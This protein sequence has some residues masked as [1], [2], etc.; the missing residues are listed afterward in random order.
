M[1]CFS[2]TLNPA[3]GSA[4]LG[5]LLLFEGEGEFFPL[6]EECGPFSAEGFQFGGVLLGLIGGGEVAE[7]G[8]D[9]GYG[10]FEA[11]DLL[12]GVLEAVFELF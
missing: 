6:G 9:G 11:G 3:S 4:G 7:A 12:F 8:F 1:G 5:G 10:V 2:Q